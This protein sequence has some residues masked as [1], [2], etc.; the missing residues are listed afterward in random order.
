MTDHMPSAK[1]AAGKRA[2]LL[3]QARAFQQSGKLLAALQAYDDLIGTGVADADI[4]RE[5]GNALSQVGEFAQAVVAYG[6]SRELAPANAETH[7]NLS[8]AWYYLGDLDQALECAQQAAVLSDELTPR[9]NLATLIPNCPSATPSQILAVRRELGQQLQQSTARGPR[10]GRR[11]R[12]P[13]PLRVGYVSAFFH[14]AN[15]M[16]PVWG[17]INQHDRSQVAVHLFR[18]S[19]PQAG[20][21]GYRPDPADRVHDTAGLRCRQLAERVADLGIDILLDLN[22]YSAPE[23]L[24]LFAH[25]GSA[26][27]VTWFNAYATTGL[28]GLQYIIGDDEVI[29]AGEEVWFSERVLRLPL[30][31]LTF[32][33]QHPVPPV[34]APPCLATRRITFGSLVAQYK[35]TGPVLD[36]W[37][38]IL[39]EAPSSRLLLA[40]TALKSVQNRAYVQDQFSRRGVLAEQLLLHGPAPHL[41][42]LGYYDQIDIALDAFPYNGGTTTME[43]LWQGVPVLAL[44]GDRWAGRTS[45]TLIRATP[46][47]SWVAPDAASYVERAVHWALSPEAPERLAAHREVARAELARSS[48]CDTARLARSMEQLFQQILVETSE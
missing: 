42:Y 17:L 36:A 46:W 8:K 33:V 24:A 10:R 23:R 1:A 43:A 22:A 26:V 4:W 13:G 48:A 38:A 45:Q 2:E 31:Y 27:Q 30:S 6:H 9:L 34:V 39:R 41:E 37:A 40:N 29:P 35:I 21:P 28:P 12:L 14:A 16:K 18:D 3:A 20:M 7:N 47:G 15:Y 44:A 25:R 5:T 11:K 32:D 19:S